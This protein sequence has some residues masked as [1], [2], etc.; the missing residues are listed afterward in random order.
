[1]ETRQYRRSAATITVAALLLS[2]NACSIL[3]DHRRTDPAVD[4][5]LEKTLKIAFVTN[6]ASD[7]WLIA[8]SGVNDADRQLNDRASHGGPKY[9]VRFIM[10]SNGTI[11]VQES[12]VNAL[13]SHGEKA[14]AISPIDPDTQTPWLNKVAQECPLITSDS[15]APLS[16]RLAYVGTDNKTAGILAGRMIKQALPHGGKIMMFVGNTKAQNAVDREAGI[17]QE[18][19]NSNIEIEGVAIDNTDRTKARGNAINALIS[20]PHLSM[21]VGLWSYNGPAIIS[22]V[23]SLHKVGKVKIV[24]F[25]QERRTLKG[26]RTGAVYA[27]IVQQPYQFGFRST[28]LMAKIADGDRSDL[29]KNGLVYFPA[30]VVT[31]DNI[32][33]YIAKLNKET[34]KTWDSGL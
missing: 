10:P 24:C 25:D 22:A 8:D 7:Y 14:I 27:T 3:S 11:A 9:D 15:D 33:N 21:E 28:E 30:K 26:I 20:H 31:S 34:G 29:P 13:V 6:N 23:E 1:L 12:I 32:L 4:A 2:Q 19:K 18:L 17:R 16:N 5:S